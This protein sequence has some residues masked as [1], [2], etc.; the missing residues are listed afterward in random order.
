MTN[1]KKDEIAQAATGMLRDR[2]YEGVS[3]SDIAQAVG[4]QK[5]TLYSHFKNKDDLASF[6]LNQALVG[7]IGAMNVTGNRRKDFIRALQALADYLY[8]EK[9][10]IG[11]HLLY[12]LPEEETKRST[13]HFFNALS[14]HLKLILDGV[15]SK[16]KTT[17]FVEETLS[18]VEGSVLWLMLNDDE[19]P[20]KRLIKQR[21]KHLDQLVAEQKA[22][23]L[24]RGMRKEVQEL[25]LRHV[26]STHRPT[27]TEIALAEELAQLRNDYFALE[28]YVEADSCSK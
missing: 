20:M 14:D 7:L 15:L 12:G 27:A 6:A 11:W 1:A 3:M 21:I 10:C 24:R 25:L 19:K 13:G 23:T 17:Y 9:K 2:G 16:K 18:V 8:Q 5:S 4:V 22:A 28:A 26:P